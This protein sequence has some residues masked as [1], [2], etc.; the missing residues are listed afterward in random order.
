MLQWM[1]GAGSF[2]G[3]GWGSGEAVAEGLASSVGAVL[4]G[5]GRSGSSVLDPVRPEEWEPGAALSVLV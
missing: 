3:V 4:L 1:T 2:C 5:S